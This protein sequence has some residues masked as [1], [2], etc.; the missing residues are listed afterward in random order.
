MTN[1]RYLVA[2]GAGFIGS[3]LIEALLNKDSGDLRRKN[4][5]PKSFNCSSY[6]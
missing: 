6:L 3:H 4:G 1:Y 5:G 2:G